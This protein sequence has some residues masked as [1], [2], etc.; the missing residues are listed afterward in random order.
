LTGYN[1]ELS[2]ISFQEKQSIKGG[3]KSSPLWLNNTLTKL[4]TWN[5]EKIEERAMILTS[6]AMDIWVFPSLDKTV[7]EKYRTKR[8]IKDIDFDEEDHYENGS[9]LTKTIYE[10][11]RSVILSIGTNIIIE[12]KKKYVAFIHNTNF[13]DIVFRRSKLVVYINMKKG[14]LENPMHLAIDI[15]S[16]H[17]GNGDYMVTLTNTK[18]IEKAIPLI[19]QSYNEN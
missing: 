19:R 14:T 18:D 9:E 17:W 6:L 11:L 12:P 5:R 7:L 8:E 16:G 13:V 3:F 2:N 1:S 4:D 10:S 15:S